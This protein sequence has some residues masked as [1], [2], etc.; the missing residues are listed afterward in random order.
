MDFLLFSDVQEIQLLS[1]VPIILMGHSYG[2]NVAYEVAYLLHSKYKISIEYFVAIAGIS[3]NYLKSLPMYAFSYGDG[4]GILDMMR[5]TGL[6][7]FGRIPDYLDASGSDFQRES[8][9]QGKNNAQN[10]QNILNDVL[11]FRCEIHTTAHSEF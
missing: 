3:M 6:A 4:D 1:D 5:T 9:I 8:A 10:I 11:L 7:M 2:C